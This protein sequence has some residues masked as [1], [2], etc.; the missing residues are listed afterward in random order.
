MLEGLFKEALSLVHCEPAARNLAGRLRR[1]TQLS[2][3][4]VLEAGL[5]VVRCVS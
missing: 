1:A 4:E 5:G 3:A 2:S